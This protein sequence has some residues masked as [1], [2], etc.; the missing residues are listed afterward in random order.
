MKYGWEGYG[1]YWAML[2]AMYET[3]DAKLDANL[4]RALC[5]RFAIAEERLNSFI[6]D[7]I[8][9]GLFVRHDDRLFS[10]RLVAEKAIAIEKSQSARKSAERRWNGSGKP[11]NANALRTQSEGNAPPTPPTNPPTTGLDAN[12]SGLDGEI[13]QKIVEALK[14]HGKSNPHAY[15][16]SIESK[17]NY[18]GDAILS[19]WR[20]WKT[21]SGMTVSTFYSRCLQHAG[22]EQQP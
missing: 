10:E 14:L 6:D 12:A 21:T 22:V 1:L 9:T 7:C 20:E 2:E 15:L 5:V 18:N 8:A 17:I 4:L 13:R 19:A 16:R 11:T 3:A